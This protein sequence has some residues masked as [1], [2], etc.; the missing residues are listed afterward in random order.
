MP[1]DVHVSKYGANT[2]FGSGAAADAEDGPDTVSAI[3]ITEPSRS[4]R[5]SR[6]CDRRCMSRSPCASLGRR[7]TS[8]P[9]SSPSIDIGTDG[10]LHDRPRLAPLS[11]ASMDTS[12]LRDAMAARFP[13][14][15]ENLER[16]VRI[17]SVS[18]PEFDQSNVRRSAEATAEI[19]EAS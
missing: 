14:A 16:L 8:V 3:S 5:L 7:L 2:W 4:E 12:T 17:P 18:F 13:T 6:A 15:R 9:G 1:S 10:S 11:C 19:L